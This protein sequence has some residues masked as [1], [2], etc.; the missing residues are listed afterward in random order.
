MCVPGTLCRSLPLVGY[1]TVF[2]GETTGVFA[3]VIV[4]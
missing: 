4:L 1:A 2:K 3:A